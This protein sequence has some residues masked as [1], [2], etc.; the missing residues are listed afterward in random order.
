MINYFELK[1]WY[2][3][4]AEKIN[5][6]IVK[7]IYNIE[8]GVVFELYKPGLENKFLYVIPGKI[9]FL[10]NVKEREEANNFI[11]KLRKDFNETRINIEIDNND[12][13]IIIKNNEKKMYVEL[14]PNGLLIITDYNDTI[15]YANQYKNFG[16]RKIFRNEKYTKPPGSV[17]IINNINEFF[18][19]INNTNKKDVVRFLAIDLSLGGKYAEYIL[20]KLNIDKS[21]SPKELNKEEIEKI[22][23]IYN[24]IINLKVIVDENGN[25]IE[26]IN[27]YFINL[28]LNSRENKR[29]KKL[30]EEKEK[31]KR[32]IEEQ[33]KY[34][35]DINKEINKLEK[36]GEFLNIYSWIFKDY[37]INNII[38]KFREININ[39]DIKKDNKYLI[40]NIDDKYLE[41]K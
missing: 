1:K 34:L 38:E 18:E 29:I 25:I 26:D 33:K 15:L 39:I 16:V 28:Y 36:I 30:N 17:N 6:S 4:N 13:I 35:E 32:I 5:N 9:I 27:K 14:F 40:I 11:L 22:Y 12:K 2:N 24:D 37:D 3:E 41:N 19:K 10:Y 7:N 31:I 20:K 21:K 8:D 23:S